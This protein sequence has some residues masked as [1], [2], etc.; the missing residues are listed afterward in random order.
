MSTTHSPSSS[1]GHGL[2]SSPFAGTD[3]TLYSPE[4]ARNVKAARITN[5]VA[6]GSK[7]SAAVFAEKQMTLPQPEPHVNAGWSNEI[8]EDAPE[9]ISRCQLVTQL[10]DGTDAGTDIDH[11]LVTA[12]HQMKLVSIISS[13]SLYHDFANQPQ[14]RVLHHLRSGL[15]PWRLPSL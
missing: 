13:S 15:H 14:V 3:P 4:L 7:V 8:P 5:D 6:K 12:Q 10:P 2:T 11:E 1:A 9:Y